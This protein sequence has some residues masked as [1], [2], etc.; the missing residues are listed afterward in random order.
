[1]RAFAVFWGKHP[2]YIGALIVGALS[3]ALYQYII[4]KKYKNFPFAIAVYASALI[5]SFLITL[6]LC[7]VKEKILETRGI[8]VEVDFCLYYNSMLF[9]GE[10]MVLPKI[11]GSEKLADKAVPSV[12][13]FTAIARV[14]CVAAGCCGG[15][16][17]LVEIF[18]AVGF[19]VI[20]EIKR[21]NAVWYACAYSLFRFIIEFF[22]PSYVYENLFGLSAFQLV[23][24]A[25]TVISAIF[26]VKKLIEN[27]E[28]GENR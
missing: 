24:L 14:G 26:I 21:L 13:V 7:S 19:L 22:K 10:L 16:L 2:I 23:C 27:N 5:T 17:N 4:R 11:F 12:L 15:A 8:K 1:M 28:I 18:L 6:A 25:V 3:A 20:Y 9:L